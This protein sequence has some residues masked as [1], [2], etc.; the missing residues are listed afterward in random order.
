M[1]A[2][3][4]APIGATGRA[5]NRVR[6]P[7]N[8]I[9]VKIEPDGATVRL[10]GRPAWVTKELLAAGKRGI[11]AKQYP[12]CRVAHYIYKYRRAGLVV[13]KVEEAHG[14]DY[15][16]HHARYFLRSQIS[17]VSENMAAAA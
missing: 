3:S 14:G 9:I 6:N 10:A 12:G 11:T 4:R 2:I 16:G 7:A 1:N 15:P 8:S 17:I 13:E 5:S